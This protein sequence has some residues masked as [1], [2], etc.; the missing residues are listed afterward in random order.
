VYFSF[1]LDRCYSGRKKKKTVAGKP[2]PLDPVLWYM[3]FLDAARPAVP[4]LVLGPFSGNAIG[5]ISGW[6]IVPNGFRP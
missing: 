2:L 6:I 5:R 1:M 4:R 3:L